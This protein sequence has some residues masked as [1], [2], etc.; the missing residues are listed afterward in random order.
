M[1]CKFSNRD[2]NRSRFHRRER[3]GGFRFSVFGFR[4]KQ[5]VGSFPKTENRKPDFDFA[6]FIFSALSAF[7]AVKS[8]SLGVLA[9]QISSVKA[10]RLFPPGRGPATPPHDFSRTSLP[11]PWVDG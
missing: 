7:S 2:C 11:Q 8:S 9:V 10:C 4:K 1:A 3:I 6:V 5:R